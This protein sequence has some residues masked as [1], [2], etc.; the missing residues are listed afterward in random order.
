MLTCRRHVANCGRPMQGLD[1]K[2]RQSWQTVVVQMQVYQDAN[3]FL[4]H[5]HGACSKLPTHSHTQMQRLQ[6]ECT[7]PNVALRR[8]ACNARTCSRS[9]QLAPPQH[10]APGRSDTPGTAAPCQ[11]PSPGCQTCRCT[12][13][14]SRLLY[15]VTVTSALLRK[16]ASRN[17][18]FGWCCCTL[19]GPHWNDTQRSIACCLQHC[20]TAARLV[21]SDMWQVGAA[22]TSVLPARECTALL[23]IAGPH[24][25]VWMGCQDTLLRLV[26]ACS[27]RRS[28]PPSHP[29]LESALCHVRRAPPKS[30]CTYG[31]RQ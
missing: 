1:Q 16:F 24:H 9:C 19:Q 8:L 11:G 7:D 3:V 6:N 2:M 31:T 14:P 23:A 26:V 10:C 28:P 4:P 17:G 30:R 18:C 12:L 29:A 22:Q 21:A 25:S 27:M 20:N 15:A 13:P 5:A